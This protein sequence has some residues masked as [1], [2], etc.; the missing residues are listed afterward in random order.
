MICEYCGNY[1]KFKSKDALYKYKDKEKKYFNVPVF[2]C[3]SC[4][5]EK[6]SLDVYTFINE[7]INNDKQFKEEIIDLTMNERN[8]Y[9]LN[10][11]Y[12]VHILVC[13][14]RLIFSL[15]NPSNKLIVRAI[16]SDGK[17]LQFIENPSEEVQ[18]A[19]VKGEGE[20]I[21]HIKDPSIRVQK[22]AI[23]QNPYSIEFIKNPSEEIK[24]Y[25]LELNPKVKKLSIYGKVI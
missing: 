19:A 8:P 1:M 17:L 4:G 22:A 20:L 10:D 18:L 7:N 15:K 16:K 21:R 12:L 6:I 3:S 25:A 9:I 2:Q 24:N 23:L 14:P 11:D 13:E 5:M